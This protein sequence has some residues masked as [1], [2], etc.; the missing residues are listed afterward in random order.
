MKIL[1][2]LGDFINQLSRDNNFSINPL[3]GESIAAAIF[4]FLALF[5]GLVTYHIFE[6]Y[7]SK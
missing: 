1:L 3:V 4:F 7:F 5:V 6:H 2:N